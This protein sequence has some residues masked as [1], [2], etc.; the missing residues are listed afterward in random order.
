MCSSSTRESEINSNEIDDGNI[1]AIGRGHNEID[2]GDIQA[3]DRLNHVVVSTTANVSLQIEEDT[4]D[5]EEHDKFLT[6]LAKAFTLSIAYA[7]NVGG[8]GTSTGTTPNIVMKGF[9][10]G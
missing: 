9:A 6:G 4:D 3:T 7:A 1:Q 8:V 5:D 2:D 10:D